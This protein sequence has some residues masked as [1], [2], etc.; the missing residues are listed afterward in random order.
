MTNTTGC[1]Y[2]APVED[3]PRERCPFDPD[4]RFEQLRDERPVTRVSTPSGL[5]VWLV[6]RYED[7]RAV[8]AD[9]DSFS[10]GDSSSSH[11]IGD[12][13]GLGG[14]AQSGVLLRLDGEA[15]SSLRLRL[16]REFTPKAIARLEPFVQ[17]LVDEHLQ[18]LRA[19][20]G[21]VDLYRAFALPIPSLVISEML[22]V[23]EAERE[24]F[25]G[26]TARLIDFS[27]PAEERDAAA[28]ELFA[29]LG[30]LVQSKFDA[31]GDDLLGRLI[32]DPRNHPVD[33]EEL[34]G[35]SIL[36][37]TAGHDTTAN[38]IT[39]GTLR[40][41]QEP[42]LAA[43]VRDEDAVLGTGI[44]ELV[45]YLTIVHLGVLRRAVRNVEVGGE[46]VHAG[47][48]VAVAL[49]SANRDPRSIEDPDRLD[50]DRRSAHVGFGYGVH[51]C[52]GQHLA[53]L[54][55]RLT[56]P[57]LLRGLPGLRT[58]Q[59]LENIPYKNE[60]VVYGVKELL[61]TWDRDGAA[62][63]TTTGT[64]V[65]AQDSTPSDLDLEAERQVVEGTR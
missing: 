55:L 9:G 1:P 50:L 37:L 32:T 29:F 40:L 11:L 54:E 8:L 41:L 56:L 61:V 39:L 44:D 16:A 30:R 14:P 57:A 60:M 31:P 34:V 21:P 45:R 63:A 38:M 22:G 23:P 58:V 64:T 7:A 17:R 62:T 5:D 49:E 27:V 42:E 47:E 13:A 36:L 48:Y 52:L 2:T 59:S 46:L 19:T 43:R 28:G 24:S 12:P 51:Q 18:R 35:L 3:L 20:Q 4:P 6:S 15:H 10:N 33:F 25:S 53:R 26:I 65:G